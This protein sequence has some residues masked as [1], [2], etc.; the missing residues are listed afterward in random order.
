[1]DETRHS[2]TIIKWSNPKCAASVPRDY[3][4]FTSPTLTRQQRHSSD[5]TES[6]FNSSCW[7]KSSKNLR[8]FKKKKMTKHFGRMTYFDFIQR[9]PTSKSCCTGNALLFKAIYDVYY[10]NRNMFEITDCPNFTGKKNTSRYASLCAEV[11]TGTAYF[12]M[13]LRLRNKGVF[14]AY[15]TGCLIAMRKLVVHVRINVNSLQASRGLQGQLD[16]CAWPWPHIF[17]A[18][19]IQL[20]FRYTLLPDYSYNRESTCG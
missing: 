16:Y 19:N 13:H 5:S 6:V 14:T 1:M 11:C 3:L 17:I 12:S 10:D 2:T 20:L 18:K 7:S 8:K 15:Q 4:G 9:T